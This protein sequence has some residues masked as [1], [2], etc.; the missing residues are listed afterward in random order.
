MH[1]HGAPFLVF[2]VLVASP[3]LAFAQT[4]PVSFRN[5]V[6][7]VLSKAGCNQGACHGNQNGK[8]GFKLSLRGEDPDW[9]LNALTR[10]TLGRRTNPFRPVESL[11]LLK[12]TAAVP[13]EGGQRFR[14]DSPEYALLSR[15]IAE[16]MQ[17]DSPAVPVLRELRV[18]PLRQVLTRLDEPIQIQAA[19]VF[20]NGVTR[21]V[22][23]LAVHEPL[24]AIASIGAGG[25]VRAERYGEAL[26]LVRYLDR[27]ATVRLAFIPDR[28]GFQWPDVP[29]NNYID[30]HVF[31]RLRELRI[32][33]SELCSDQV[34]LRR[35]HLDAIG[36]LPSA[37]EVRAFLADRS[38]DK[39][40]RL[41]DR[42]L[43]RPEFADFWALKWSDLLRNEEKTL[44]R[45]GVQ[46]FHNWL[47]QS[48]AEGKPLNELA[49]ELVAAR[50]S[51]YS[52]PPANY[53]RAL[54]DPHARVE[55]TAQVFLGLRLQCVKCHNHPFD[56][57]KQEDYY[58]LAAFF[59][60]V[61]YKIVEN[62]RRDRF[63]QHEFDGEQ[64][65]VFAREGEIVHPRTGQAM[66]PR[67][68]G[69]GSPHAPREAIVTRSVT[70]TLDD[71]LQA[72]ADW[73]AGPGNEYF[74]RAQ[75]NRIW[76]HL[77]KRGIV[78][79]I[80]DFRDSNPP[81]NGPL[82]D[83][84][85]NDLVEHRFD[86]K[87]LVRTILSS[88][89]YQ[90]AALPNETNRDDEAN[91]ARALVQPLPA[92]VLLDAMAGAVDAPIPFS[93]Y[94]LGLRAGQLPGV[95]TMRPREQRPSDGERFMKLFGKPERLLSCECER[96]E[97]TTLTQ[98]F[99]LISGELMN[100]LLAEPDSRLGRL[101]AA[102]KSDLEVLEELYLATLTRLPTPAEVQAAQTH[103][104]KCKDRRA[105]FEDLLWGMLNAK[106]FLL[107]H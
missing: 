24:N 14:V 80:D 73:I 66:A 19:A 34:F 11:I 50:G 88:R 10:D 85:A 71:P 8:N 27:Q 90:L 56:R 61:S 43:E 96:S 64:V 52:N 49:R 69:Q 18:T 105:G 104:A 92:E 12:A 29:E 30:R 60:R 9:D 54:R 97:D 78:D 91:F 63:D 31:A 102:G 107:R 82:L 15:W 47:R 32:A 62:N 100:R 36:L 42:L 95:R 35:A 40:A 55:A 33:P 28:P 86:L 53:Y 101:L 79:P 70:S 16:G 65:V 77:M 83:A 23:R 1:S 74:A 94:P 75:A 41:I 20:S 98:A 59:P 22:S 6:M 5:E 87:H 26:V 67:F 57:W 25:L 17:R 3:T 68:L 46:V 58:G 51:T 4:E 81:S 48:I 7:A 21:D 37:G 99:Q 76:F 84:L 89:T 106:E 93:G 103:L 38:P 2:A 13:H 39:R 45:K 72:L 44:D